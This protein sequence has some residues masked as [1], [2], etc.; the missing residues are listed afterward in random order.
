MIKNQSHFSKKLKNEKL[1]HAT[2][3]HPPKF[4]V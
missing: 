2:V 1:H 4:V 3:M